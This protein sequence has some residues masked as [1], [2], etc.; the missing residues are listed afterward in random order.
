MFERG[1]VLV[2]THI[3]DRGAPFDGY[4]IRWFTHTEGSFSICVG[5]D[6]EDKISF[7]L[8]RIWFKTIEKAVCEP[9]RLQAG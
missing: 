8:D 7:K 5:L 9:A 6:Y 1:Q 3:R 4:P 2:L